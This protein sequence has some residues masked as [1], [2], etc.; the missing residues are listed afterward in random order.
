MNL[1]IFSGIVQTYGAE[2]LIVL[3]GDII[4]IVIAELVIYR[5]AERRTKA[6][7]VIFPSWGSG[8]IG[9]AVGVRNKTVKDARVRYWGSSWEPMEV[10]WE[11]RDGTQEERKTLYVG[12]E[13]AR[14]YPFKT[15]VT[16]ERIEGHDR[17]DVSVQEIFSPYRS[18]Y[19]KRMDVPLDSPNFAF[20]FKEQG[21]RYPYRASIRIVGE[22]AEEVKDYDLF[23]RIA[24]PVVERD[25]GGDVFVDLRAEEMKSTFFG[26]FKRKS[27]W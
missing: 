10:M 14:F 22:G 17:I 25:R 12:D 4:A 20:E 26:G 18:V 23:F 21:E 27:R 1:D 15:K 7:F 13:P 3:L 5:Y 24:P 2:F 11:N 19:S 9:F 8:K 16:H 6:K